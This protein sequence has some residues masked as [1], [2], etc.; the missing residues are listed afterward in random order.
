MA[1]FNPGSPGSDP[2]RE[3]R[4]QLLAAARNGKSAAMEELQ[5][6]FRVRLYSA[7]E[8]DSLFYTAIP[9]PSGLS[10]KDLD[11]GMEW[12]RGEEAGT[13]EEHWFRPSRGAWD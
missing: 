5:Q 8:R 12:A 4:R 3:Y 6:E 7:D 2:E 10:P 1:S 13:S 11:I 9:Q